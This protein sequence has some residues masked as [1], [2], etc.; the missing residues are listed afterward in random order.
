MELQFRAM[1]PKYWLNHMAE[2]LGVKPRNGKVV[3]PSSLGKGYLQQ[4][5]LEEELYVTLL[6]VT[7]KKELTLTRTATKDVDYYPIMFY[8]L[9]KAGEQEIAGEVL[10]I[11]SYT[12]HAVFFP[13]PHIDTKYHYDK[14]KR[15]LALT[16]SASGNWLKAHIDKSRASIKEQLSNGKPFFFFEELTPVLQEYANLLMQRMRHQLPSRLSLSAAAYELMDRCFAKINERLLGIDTL[17]IHNDDL[18]QLFEV[19]RIL[20]ESFVAPPTVAELARTA[21]MGV[22]KLQQLFKQVYG[23]SIYQYVLY[24]KM[25][26]ARRLLEETNCTVAEAG[27]SVG[28]DN[29][30][31]FATAFKKIYNFTPKAFSK[32]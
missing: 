31:H 19:Q 32:K 22:T 6:D 20:H 16:I 29:L 30:S 18:Q 2:Q 24:I 25:R 5:Q 10:N 3:I 11:G 13:S 17:S 28:Y 14:N 8:M 7:L 9:H 21:G 27:M 1:Q 26:E 12:K 23:K 4:L 15:I